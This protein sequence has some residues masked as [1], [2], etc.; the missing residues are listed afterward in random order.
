MDAPRITLLQSQHE[1]LTAF[2]DGHP[3]GHERAAVVFFRRKCWENEN[4]SDSD[5]YIAVDVQPFDDSWVTSSSPIS[6]SFSLEPLRECFR[7]CE[8]EG[9]VFGFIHSHPTGSPDFS[10]IDEDNEQ[11][12]LTAIGNRNGRDVHFVAMLWANGCWNGRVRSATS[13]AQSL[14]VRHIAVLGPRLN[15]HAYK[16]SPSDNA[17]IAARQAAAF[18]Q[19]FV[20]QLRV[21]R[22][23]VVGAGGTGSPT[24]ELLA[25][26][27][28]GEIV[29]ID[30]D[31]LDESNL[32]RVR[33]AGYDDIGKCKSI[34]Q[35]DN[36]RSLNLPSKIVALD[37]LVD[38]S[39]NAIDA[40]ASCDLVF[41]CT[42]DQIGRSVLTTALYVFALAYIDI[43]LG[44]AIQEDASGVQ[45]LRYHFA[46]ISTVLPEH[47]ECLYC[48][49]V[50]NDVLI[51]R[52][53]ALRADPT[54]SEEELAERYLV[55]GGEDAPGVGPFTS[56]AADFGVQ[57][58]YDLL[59]PFR[60]RG[61][62]LRH[63]YVTI[64]FVQMSI[65]SKEF[66]DDTDCSYCQ[67]HMFTLIRERYR[68]DRPLLGRPNV[69]V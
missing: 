15:L 22:I 27:G 16:K 1:L 11:T 50:I 14:P 69:A 37:C 10:S 31:K 58:F 47:G 65:R 53:Y 18:G 7:R 43:G 44:G 39:A 52:Q 55:G 21:L 20:D 49:G 67:Q 4:L 62:E 63:D 61:P 41:G 57:A 28:V 25:R 29:V 45:Q 51:Q 17:G 40:I 32:N 42:D 30:A 12:L 24:I 66:L 56:A 13:T 46:R 38:L 9:L 64:D 26:A 34:I 8:E 2:L 3:Q 5:R 60:R 6:I 54:L 59:R 23:A 68:L 35:Q 48:Q 36:I 33:G 19:P